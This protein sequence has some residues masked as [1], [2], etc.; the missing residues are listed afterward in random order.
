MKSTAEVLAGRRARTITAHPDDSIWYRTRK[1]L[2]AAYLDEGLLTKGEAGKQHKTTDRFAEEV[3]AAEA[4]GYCGVTWYR[5][6]D[7]Q[8]S[9]PDQTRQMADRIKAEAM[10]DRIG[11]FL[12]G[13][14][15]DHPDHIAT[16]T[17]TLM[18]AEE[19]AADSYDIA[20]LLRTDDGSGT[21]VA[22][23][24]PESVATTFN[25]MKAHTQWEMSDE[26]RPDWVWT[27]GNYYLHPRDWEELSPYGLTED[28]GYIHITTGELASGGLLHAVQQKPVMAYTNE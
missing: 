28:A 27:P 3:I 12:G 1:S 13:L 4:L 6:V 22:E 19:M 7:G 14:F 20:V 10:R 8:L 26:P 21:H 23:A 25:A 17:A 9:E 18:A 11:V 15:F 24:A 5:G 16:V 2:G